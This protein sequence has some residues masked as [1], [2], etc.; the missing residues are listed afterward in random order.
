MDLFREI[1]GRTPWAAVGIVAVLL[2]LLVLL[3][4]VVWQLFGYTLQALSPRAEKMPRRHGLLLLTTGLAA[5]A[6]LLGVL[7]IPGAERRHYLVHLVWALALVG[8][9]TV[10]E[11]L[12]GLLFARRRLGLVLLLWAI[13]FSTAVFAVRRLGGW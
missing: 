7:F 1:Y 9:Y 12:G 8:L 13:L 2:I 11:G 10:A 3:G 6:A 4:M 5:W